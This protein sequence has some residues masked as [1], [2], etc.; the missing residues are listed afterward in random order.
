MS[1]KIDETALEQVLKDIRWNRDGLVPAVVQ[2][3]ESGQVLMLAY[4]NAEALKRTVKEGRA[5]Y[6]SR[7]RQSLWLKGETSGHFQ[8]VVD[9]RF[10]CDRDAVLLL[11]KQTGVACHELFF[12]FS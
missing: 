6:Y 7:S 12:L 11:V 3:V 5:C 1:N 2:D 8:E 9:L 4:M 10:D